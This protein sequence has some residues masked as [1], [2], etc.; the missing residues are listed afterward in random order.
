[1]ARDSW[2]AEVLDPWLGGFTLKVMRGGRSVNVDVSADGA[3]LVSHAGNALLAEVADKL[4]LTRELSAGLAGVKQRDRGHDPGRVIRDLVVMIA[5]GG[6]CIA[7]LGA[8]RD[9]QALFGPVASDSTAFRVID[10][11]ASEGLCWMVC[12]RL[13]LGAGSGSGS[14]TARL[15]R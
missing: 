13:M 10:R 14:C 15:R 3:G 4:G 12:A 2:V 7:D 8:V 5:S 11:A 9:Q 6:E 1:L